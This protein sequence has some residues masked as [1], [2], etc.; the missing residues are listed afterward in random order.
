MDAIA[1]A[2]STGEEAYPDTSTTPDAAP[3]HSAKAKKVLTPTQRAVERKKRGE[4]RKRLT[5]SK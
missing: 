4:W 3:V 1:A 5:A 2:E